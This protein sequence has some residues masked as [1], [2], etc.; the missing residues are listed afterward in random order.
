MIGRP[1]RASGVTRCCLGWCTAS[2]TVGSPVDDLAD[3]L[4]L[5]GRYFDPVWRVTVGL[6]PLEQQLLRTWWVRRLLFVAHAG[7]ASVVSVQSYSRLEHSLGLLALVSHFAPE[8]R[9]ARAAALLH[10]VGHLPLSHTFEGLH[11]LDHHR[12]ADARIEELAPLLHQ[13]GVDPDAVRNAL[14]GPRESV[15]FGRP[16][17]LRLDHLESLVR[18]GH[19]HG[20]TDQPAHLMLGRLRLIDGVVDTDRDTADLLAELIVGEARAQASP[21]N[22]IATG[23]VRD[24][25]DR[26]L[27]GATPSEIDRV[28][29][30]TDAEF[31]ALLLS[32]AETGPITRRFMRDPLRWSVTPAAANLPAA[33]TGTSRTVF[34][35]RRLY[36]DVPDI[37]GRPAPAGLLAPGLPTVQVDFL[38]TE[39]ASGES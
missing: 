22:M 20:R 34:R 24:L 14:E 21:V 18:S 7:A 27:A 3:T 9:V 6:T 36:L 25:A 1:C 29:V 19:T 23:V 5:G 16:G 2:V 11:G 30:M 4:G 17:G 33:D 13:Y 26:V 37:D 39:A 31:W 38:I 15:L 8:D 12:L 35:L 32:H 10:D 28:A